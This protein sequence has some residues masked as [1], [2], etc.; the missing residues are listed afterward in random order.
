MLP[1]RP[2]SSVELDGD[3]P[4]NTSR[5]LFFCSVADVIK[6]ASPLKRDLFVG[7]GPITINLRCIEGNFDPTDGLDVGEAPATIAAAACGFLRGDLLGDTGTS[8]AEES[9]I[10]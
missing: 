5:L 1:S 3:L 7:R 10:G 9:P 6:N 8:G 2:L 4:A